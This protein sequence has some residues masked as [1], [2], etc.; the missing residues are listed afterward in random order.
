MLDSPRSVRLHTRRD[1]CLT[2]LP[3]VEITEIKKYTV[4][5]NL[6]KFSPKRSSR[7]LTIHLSNKELSIVKLGEFLGGGGKVYNCNVDGNECAVKV[8][9][10]KFLSDKDIEYIRREIEIMS[11]LPKCPNLVRYIYH[12]ETP[13][14]IRI[15]MKKYETTLGKFVSERQTLFD[16]KDVIRYALDIAKGVAILHECRIIHRDLKTHNIFV[17][18]KDG[19][20]RNMVV[21]DFDTSRTSSP[22]GIF[23]TCIGTPV[24]IAPEV[25]LN[26]EDG[27][28]ISADIWSFGMILYELMTCKTPYYDVKG[29]AVNK[30]ILEGE[31]P[32]LPKNLEIKYQPLMTLWKLCLLPNPTFRPTAKEIVTLLARLNS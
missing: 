31:I 24:Y 11:T 7:S 1:S 2:K 6:E 9:N 25:L 13:E 5:Y 17:D 21:G 10:L 14:Q 18:I 26:E 4:E 28:N 8:Y 16:L 12:S 22:R 23:N 19:V 27:Y 32:K 20:V 29:F 30:K 15:F 3:P